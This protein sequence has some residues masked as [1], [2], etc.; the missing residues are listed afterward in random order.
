MDL[1]TEARWIWCICP[2]IRPR[3]WIEPL[4][5]G[6]LTRLWLQSCFYKFLRRFRVS[7]FW[8]FY[9]WTLSWVIQYCTTA[10]VTSCTLVGS[11]MVSYKR[12]LQTTSVC[13]HS[14]FVLLILWCC[15]A[16]MISPLCCWCWN[17]I[18][19]GA[20][21]C[22]L[23]ILFVFTYVLLIVFTR[24]MFEEFLWVLPSLVNVSFRND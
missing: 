11:V 6:C 9:F 21:L 24:W 8:S 1:A 3:N 2:I 14:L 7:S 16:I 22:C 17:V 19:T 10:L 15:C 13:F 12:A 5:R 20:V 23:H 18:V 4:P